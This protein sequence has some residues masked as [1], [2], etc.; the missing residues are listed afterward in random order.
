MKTHYLWQTALTSNPRLPDQ[1]NAEWGGVLVKVPA[2]PLSVQYIATPQCWYINMTRANGG[3][4]GHCRSQDILSPKRDQDVMQ[5]APTQH[6]QIQQ[7]WSLHPILQGGCKIIPLDLSYKQPYLSCEIS[8]TIFLRNILIWN[9]SIFC[10]RLVKFIV[11][12]DIMRETASGLTLLW[13]ISA[14]WRRSLSSRPSQLSR[15]I[16]IL[17]ASEHSVQKFLSLSQHVFILRS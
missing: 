4:P 6:Q 14:G 17:L 9:N 5:P 1:L 15:D 2:G 10:W 16:K 8:T 11:C 13:W 12:S 3:W 7:I